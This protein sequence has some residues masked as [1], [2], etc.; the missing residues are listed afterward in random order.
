MTHKIKMKSV[1]RLILTVIVTFLSSYLPAR[2]QD[3]TNAT[4]TGYP[5]N[6]IVQGTN[7]E[8][9]QVTNGNLHVHIPIWSAKGRGLNTGGF[10]VYDSKE[11]SFSNHC[12]TS[13]ICVDTVIAEPGNNMILTA[14][15]AKDYSVSYKTV[16]RSCSGVVDT[17]KTNVVLR[18]PDGTKHH[19]VPDP[20]A[21]AGELLCD[22]SVITT[23]LYANDGSGWMIK[24]DSQTNILS[25]ESKSGTVIPFGSAQIE[26]SNGNEL[27]TTDTLGRTGMGGLSYIDSSG[28]Q[29]SATISANTSVA[30]ATH[31]CIFSTADQCTEHTSTWT[32][33]SVLT[34]PNGMQYSFGYAQNQG[35]EI[36]S[37]TLPT[38]GQVTYTYGPWKVG[39]RPVATRAVI[40]NG[41][42]GTWTY[43]ATGPGAV[44]TDPGSNDTTYDCGPSMTGDPCL[45][46]NIKYYSGSYTTGTLL[47]TELTDYLAIH[48]GGWV[49][50]YINVPIRVTTTWAQPN[51]VTKIETD[52]DTRAVTGGTT[53][54][55][56]PLET[57]EYDF[58]SGTFGALLRRTH[59][60]YL[61][62]QNTSYL[63]ANIADRQTSK[64]VYNGSGTIL[65]Q[66]T[67][68]YDGSTPTATSGVPNHDYT[69]FSSANLIR[70][71][72]TTIGRW[73]NTTNTWLNTTNTY[74]DLGNL[75]SISDPL[76]HT[77]SFSYAD[78][79]TDG[80]N[81]NAQAFVTQQTEP[82]TSGF[83][84]VTRNSYFW[85][86]SLKAAT[87]GQN[88]PAGTACSNTASIPQPDY[89]RY[90]FDLMNRSSNVTR[91]DG[92]QTNYSY[93]DSSLPMSLSSTESINST[94]NL[95]KTTLLDGMGRTKQTQ[96]TSDSQGA[97][98]QDTTYDSFG[99]IASVSN[100]YRNGADITTTTGT[101][102]YGYDQLSRKISE[103]Y[104]DTFSLTTAHCGPYT[105]VT[106]P[107]GKWRRSRTN[108]LGQL[109]EVV[110]P[111]SP[112]AS[113]ASNGCPGT[114]EPVWLTTY[115]NDALGNLT[116]VLQNASRARSFTYD[117]L[118]RL[119]CSS[120]PESATAACPAFGATTFPA[121]TVSYAYNTDNTLLSKTDARG[122][123]TTYSYDAIHRE[124]A[125]TYSNGDPTIATSYDQSACLALASC[126][127]IGRR[128]NVIDAAGSESWAFD[129]LDRINRNQRT[130]NSITKTT[131]YNFDY[132]G[133]T[134]SVTYPTGRVVNYT[135]DSANRPSTAVDN[136]NGITYATG[137][138]TS[139]GSTCQ[140]SV[141]CYTPQGTIYA[142]SIGQSSS[143]TNGLN[144]THI[145]NNRLQPKEFKAT[146]SGGNAIDVT[147]SYADPSNGN[148][149]A[150]HVFSTTNVL[151]STR[152]Q[153]FTY[154][155]L[156][157]ITS[158]LTTSTHATSPAHC[159]G[160]TYTLDAWANL[161]SIAA[162]TNP[163]YTGCSQ[164]SG[165][166]KTSA[167]NQLS[168]FSYDA[169]GNTS[170]DGT[171]T[172]TWNGESQLKT[173]GGVTYSY[174]GDGRRVQ[175]SNGKLY[176]YGSD[177]EILAETNASGT[178]TAEYIFFGGK[179]VAMLPAGSTAQF[180]VEDLLDTS[181]VI[182]TNTGVV[183]YDAD[184]YPYGGERN[185]INSCAQNVY[186]F[187][188]KERDA[189][190]GNDD[191]G[192][193][194][195]SSRFGRWLSADWSAVPGPVPYA[196]LSNPQT[197]NLYSMVADDPESFAD[198]DGHSE[199]SWDFAKGVVKGFASSVSF[200][201]V[202]APRTSD[203]PSSLAGQV[204]GTGLAGLAGAVLKGE[205]AAQVGIGLAAEGP[206]AGTS[207]ALVINGAVDLA[208]GQAVQ[209]GAAANL[210]RIAA[211]GVQAGALSKPASGKGSVPPDQRDPQRV[212]TPKQKQE[213]LKQQNGNCANCGEKVGDGEGIGHHEERHADGGRTTVGPDGNVKVVCD[214]CHKDLH[215]T[216][217]A[218]NVKK[219]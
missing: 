20:A 73:L 60:N 151:D 17:V 185:Y 180:Y 128:T 78:N 32:A 93:N 7:I 215:S 84:H 192:A 118:S 161:L 110:E 186:K 26:D 214:P 56:N 127:N 200:G 133:N 24:L 68:T 150:G 125:R 141:T 38:G 196:N 66:T 5:E 137:L 207:T 80:V 189:E 195:Y 132:T 178:V 176:W 158:A 204:S 70:G 40:A 2:A 179:R 140:V 166:A 65:A 142:V 88:F 210:A 172:Y 116:N 45:T 81:R 171:F 213:Q 71:N 23:T 16:S 149:N 59:Y 144:L 79:F 197:L 77:T 165:F 37:I 145:Y 183:C 117:S 131:T 75:L 182:T 187:E 12:F 3:V 57:R 15:G 100:P 173:A 217:P 111:N 167:N 44:V 162:T 184:F 164:E 54:W 18:E 99:R 96:L 31:L 36:T 98:Y 76:N 30:V 156:N 157:R 46:K 34:L 10:M 138:K 47:K 190:T 49:S 114:G 152:S 74:D 14:H 86:T 147:Y 27:T 188:G 194:Y 104:P 218:P 53:T 6:A 170:G 97:I 168:G 95:S 174:D 25:S 120:N 112:T 51:L 82:V 8:S 154:D 89:A 61:H 206:S 209:A 216:P 148:K 58:G 52:W 208:V 113:V 163:A 105:L 193:R 107:D 28:V 108:G 90:S 123:T 203:S 102:T 177:G 212:A 205:G 50:N 191:F 126:A 39:G 64:I 22:G 42:T 143:F 122:I 153:T 72:P 43:A 94:T 115:I 67:T 19:F 101:T 202:G 136:S 62:L 106:D 35:A 69:N 63:N 130:T 139:P 155:Q 146:S 33:P 87:C 135:Y 83:T 169:S 91:G 13:G 124:L 4:N 92:G 159:W 121:G 175:K 21:H 85:Y 109:I 219:D 181:R 129:A 160:E 29:R 48:I 55:K 9:V 211:A 11:W 199:D 198:L 41:V 1:A 201:L 103:T 119:D 134:T